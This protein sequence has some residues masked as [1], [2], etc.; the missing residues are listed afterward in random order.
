VLHAAQAAEANGAPGEEVIMQTTSTDD[1][2]RATRVNCTAA[3]ALQAPAAEGP[4]DVGG[5]FD[6]VRLGPPIC[7]PV[8]P[9]P[10]YE[11]PEFELLGDPRQRQVVA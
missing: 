9:W 6:S 3:D 1:R 11:R 10:P 7:L 4:E 8:L 5:Y 2:G